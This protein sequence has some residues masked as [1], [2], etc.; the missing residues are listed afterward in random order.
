MTS[1]YIDM[2]RVRFVTSNNPTILAFQEV[3]VELVAAFWITENRFE[4][5]GDLAFH[6][7]VLGDVFGVA[8]LTRN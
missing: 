7:T 1:A 6:S 5:G 8:G 2:K 3:F 4:F